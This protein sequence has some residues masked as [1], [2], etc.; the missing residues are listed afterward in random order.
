MASR[1]KSKCH[2]RKPEIA[3]NLGHVTPQEVIKARMV[4]LWGKENIT[5]LARDSGV[6]RSSVSKIL[7]Y[8]RGLGDDV[9]PKL[10]EPL[11]LAWE[12]IKPPE[13]EPVNLGTLLRRLEE[14]REQ[15]EVGRRAL[16]RSLKA[17]HADLRRIE[18]RLPREAQ[19]NQEA[20]P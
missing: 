12:A 9:G 8:K 17:I 3:G 20:R 13:A 19:P 4:E 7:N 2:F 16:A 18:A 11:G 1:V 10:A 15:A 14:A 6:D 5:R